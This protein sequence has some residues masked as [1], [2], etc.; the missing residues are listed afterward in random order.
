MNTEI[1]T[2]LRAW[3]WW[4]GW[5]APRNVKKYKF[6]RTDGLCWSLWAYYPQSKASKLENELKRMFQADGLDKTY[7]FGCVDFDT[8]SDNKTMHLCPNRIAWVI[9]VLEANPDE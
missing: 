4:V 8:R 9:K 6:R 1:K 7:P 2:F 5:G 3:L